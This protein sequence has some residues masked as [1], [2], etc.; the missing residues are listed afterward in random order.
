[1]RRDSVPS[2]EFP[3]VWDQTTIRSPDPTIMKTTIATG[4]LAAL[5]TSQ[6]PAQLLAQDTEPAKPAAAPASD[7]TQ[8]PV[9]PVLI[10][11]LLGEWTN[12]LKSTLTI[13]A[14]DKDTGAITGTYRSPSGTG[15]QEF[16][17]TGWVNTAP[18][19]SKKDNAV[20]ISFS[21]RWGKIG[22]VTSWTGYYALVDS[23]ATIVGQWNLARA[24]SDYQWDHIVAGQDRFTK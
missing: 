16:P 6:F 7:I 3:R 9:D 18:A 21:V 10:K 14:I 22:S 5:F 15:G 4:I 1:M 20:I 8:N 11:E 17:L 23:N 19:Q 12:S 24:N 13:K 2:L